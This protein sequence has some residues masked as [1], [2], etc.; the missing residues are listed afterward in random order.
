MT[1]KHKLKINAE[2]FQ[3]VA[4]DLIKQQAEHI[5]A[6]ENDYLALRNIHNITVKTAELF[7]EVNKQQKQALKK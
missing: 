6:L 1:R 5:E 2:Y 7:K 3:D 4:N